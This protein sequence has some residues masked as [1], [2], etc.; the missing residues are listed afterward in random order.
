MEILFKFIGVCVCV[1]KY[2]QL[3]YDNLYIYFPS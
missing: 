2:G 3:M 1:C